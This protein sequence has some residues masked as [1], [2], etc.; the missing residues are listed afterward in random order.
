MNRDPRSLAWRLTHRSASGHAPADPRWLGVEWHD[1]MAMSRGETWREVTLSLPWLALSLFLASEELYL[2]A[3]PCS[4]MMFLT[5]LRQVHNAS[6]HSIGIGRRAND[7]LLFALSI[8]ML[9]AMHAVK[10][11][12]LRHHKHCLGEGDVEGASARMSGLGALAFGPRFPILL[13]RTALCLGNR[14]V[15][16]WV[17]AELAAMVLW[18][19]FVLAVDVSWLTYHL[20]TM[21]FAECLTAF[22][23][24]WTVHNH[25]EAA[26]FAA[27]SQRGRLKNLVSYSMFFHL[28]HHLF[29]K[30]PTSHLATLAARLDRAAPDLATLPVF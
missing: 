12:H 23:A 25:N 14:T 20:A 11:N 30:V 2:L 1:L 24:V 17:R 5:G 26:P 16:R 15:R 9:T 7:A 3:L 6:H 13:H 8:V 18:V 27:R 19:G 28:E 4:F 22:F 21:A 10:F 29:P